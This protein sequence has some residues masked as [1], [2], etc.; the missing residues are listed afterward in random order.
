MP[1]V[2]VRT[3]SRQDRR[4][5][6]GEPFEELAS[7][8]LLDASRLRDDPRVRHPVTA[9]SA[10]PNRDRGHE[11]PDAEKRETDGQQ[12]GR[13]K[14]E[15]VIGPPFPADQRRPGSRSECRSLDAC[16]TR[17]DCIPDPP[18]RAGALHSASMI[19]PAIQSR[20]SAS[21]RLRTPARLR[22]GVG[23]WIIALLL[24]ITLVT[25]QGVAQTEITFET[26]GI[27]NAYRPGGPIAARVR[28]T[29]DLDEPAPGLL[30]WE[31]PNPDGDRQINQRTIEIPGRGAST[32]TWLIGDL[33]SRIDPLAV[34]ADPWMVRLFEYR[35]GRRIREI[36]SAR[37]A[38]SVC[39]ARPIEQ[40]AGMAVV[41]GPNE[42]GLSGY[43]QIP[44]RDDRP[45]L[46]EYL[47]VVPNV[48]PPDLP[49]SWPG[50]QQADLIVWTANESR[51]QP[52][53]LGTRLVIEGALR[54]WLERG[55]H[56]VIVLPRSGDPWRLEKGDGVLN[57]LLEGIAPITVTDY[58]LQQALPALASAPGLRDP[59]RTITLHHFDPDRLPPVWR[60][61]AGFRP[62][63]PPFDPNSV[64]IPEDAPPA[65][66]EQMIET[67]R[68]M[69]PPA[70]PV[71]H[72]IRRD[73]GQG[74]LDVVGIDPSDPDIRIQQPQG[75]PATWVFWNP[76]LGRRTFTAPASVV[77]ALASKRELVTS[78]GTT[79]LGNGRLISRQIAQQGSAQSGLLLAL[80]LFGGY[81]LLAGPLGFAILGRLGRRRQAWLAF[82]GTSVLA[83]VLG[84]FV[85]EFAVVV[86]SP[87]RHLTVLRHRYADESAAADTP[88]DLATCWFSARLDGYG[89]VDVRVGDPL[90]GDAATGGLDL[91]RHYSP[92]PNGFDSG[93]VDSARYEVD[94]RRRHEIAAPA[95][96]T[97]AEFVTN[98][99]GRPMATGDAWRSTISVAPDDPVSL[100]MIDRDL[101]EVT[102]TLVNGTGLELTDILVV[103]VAPLRLA[104]LPL[105]D[106]GLPGIRG[107]RE[108]VT[109]QPPNLGGMVAVAIDSWS[110]GTP[111]PLGGQGGCFGSI[112][113]V[114]QFGRNSLG[115]ELDNR[116][117]SLE[118]SLDPLTAG[119]NVDPIVE[120]QALSLYHGLE[121]P[122]IVQTS[123]AA[124]RGSR[125]IR[126][127]GR[128]LDLSR[129]LS[130][131]GIIVLA[132]ANEAPCPVPIQLDGE[133]I[134]SEGTVLLQWIHAVPPE[135]DVLIPPRPSEFDEDPQASQADRTTVE[136]QRKGVAAAWR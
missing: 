117:Q 54:G 64:Q 1:P 45:G 119:G 84:W 49:D 70:A 17:A 98:W 103:L 126:L 13:R 86:E 19:D 129:H 51:F 63:P 28:L 90:S 2:I 52:G 111:L 61:L 128:D 27:G 5:L 97:S 18:A 56:L 4:V 60:P 121:P 124:R 92:P 7:P 80:A 62:T 23:G 48:E 133:P 16:A 66:A 35:D 11:R 127:L 105:D 37:L 79:A 76:I 40:G 104:P 85:G 47:D 34:S 110:P 39:A 120:L 94:S 107:S 125:K 21:L 36:A 59:E 81:W 96:A 73:V 50:Y 131:P 46:N 113:R 93:F 8:R 29:S 77:D 87:V 91:L 32:T 115:Y 72:A 42:A 101:V 136:S 108:R 134:A 67:A 68:G 44:G 30:E 109:T 15:P 116:F 31:I 41:I 106:S 74:T 26:F 132:V 12:H 55:G 88:F 20:L 112:R 53:T 114:P 95:R 43:G 135:I 3:Q 100:T 14:H 102:G 89:T 58:P 123:D 22:S 25:D 82:T 38:P 75:L 71:I 122:P 65:I 10:R 6:N 130:E 118:G 99:R 24:A 33:P 69:V 9:L 57:D 83:A 78:I